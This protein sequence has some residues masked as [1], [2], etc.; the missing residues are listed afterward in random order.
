MINSQLRKK[1]IDFINQNEE[2]IIKDITTLVEIK[3]VQEAPLP[4]A[5]FGKGPKDALVKA[6]EIAKNMGLTPVNCEN[7][8]GYA[9][10]KGESEKYL[11]SIGHLDVVPAGN[12]WK[13]D[14]FI[15]RN[16]EGW[17]IARGVS[18][19]KGA[20]VLSLYMLKFFKE[21]YDSIPYSL[22]AILGCNEE[23]GMLD[24]KHYVN[25]QPA[26][27]FCFTPDAAFPVCIG[28][29]G[30]S[31]FDLISPTINNTNIISFDAGSA[32]NVIPDRA[33]LVIKSDKEL[34]ETQDIK[35]E[36]QDDIYSI[37]AFGIGGHAAKPSG[38]KN[39]IGLIIDYAFSNNLFSDEEVLYMQLL[40]KLHCST[41]GK[42]LGIDADDG[43]F[44]PLTCIG[45]MINF[46]DNK[47]TQ[48]INIRY[49]TNT[50][51]EK[52]HEILSSK[53]ESIGGNVPISR[54]V[55]PFYIEPES[56]VIKSLIETYNE[57]T[58]EDEKPYVIGG[59][60]YA[61]NF[62][63]AVAFGIDF[64]NE[65]KPSFVGEVHGAEEG[66]SIKSLKDA[67]EIMIISMD[68][69]LMLDY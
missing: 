65:V 33:K 40:A 14:P 41:D 46:T 6:L 16:I 21:N 48:N 59:G 60:T 35:I 45:G 8:L 50:S 67:L 69:L 28:E 57:I 68:K 30:I 29:K 38:T 36:K 22:R 2:N 4:D 24:V 63:F 25:T 44:D 34:L 43:L 15:V 53:F 49:P 10:L 52:I 54:G 56:L 37:T 42:G 13:A 1:V 55:A 27:E 20:C 7:Y 5:P 51:F 17:L 61:R 47:Y 62:P 39:A 11:A 23:S 3:S 58:G 66:H 12:G 64:K 19:N 18:D 31:S 32:S 26:P 9:E